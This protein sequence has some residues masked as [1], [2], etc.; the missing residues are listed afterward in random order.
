[1]EIKE[2]ES[3]IFLP[4][5]S[6]FTKFVTQTEINH[7]QH[8]ISE[9][10][11]IILNANEIG[12]E[13]AEIEGDAVFFYKYNEIPTPAKLFNQVK[14]MFL[15]F[16][17]QIKLYEA[18]RICNCGACTSAVGLTLKF[19]I[20]EGNFRFINVNQNKKP[21]GADVI[22]AHRLLKNNIDSKEYALF[23][24]NNINIKHS[25]FLPVTQGSENYEGIGQVQFNYIELA[26]LKKK[27]VAIPDRKIGNLEK[28]PLTLE[29]LVESP[30][31]EVV[32]MVTN[33]E[34]RTSWNKEVDKFEYVKNRVNRQ[35][36]KHICVIGNQKISFETVT[37]DFGDNKVIYGEKTNQFPLVKNFTTYFIFEKSG[38]DYTKLTIE[39]HMTP[40]PVIGWMLVPLFKKK[41]KVEMEKTLRAIKSICENESFSLVK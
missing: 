34:L 19:V 26:P 7:S 24:N 30:V 20:H 3:L 23:T 41:M 6:G 15:D 9:L 4:D 22:L 37:N 31:N 17:S 33:L 32:E 14:R 35:G 11:E 29:T 21:Y 1:M 36:M 27:I 8:I 39:L 5:I 18:R 13:V 12:M 10:L 25:D 38:N 40:L 2:G 16:H 28:E